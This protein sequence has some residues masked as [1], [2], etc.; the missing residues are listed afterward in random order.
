MA[1]GYGHALSASPTHIGLRSP[2]DRFCYAD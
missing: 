1:D 2:I